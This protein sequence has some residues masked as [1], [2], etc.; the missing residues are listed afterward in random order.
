MLIVMR[1]HFI[2]KRKVRPASRRG[3]DFGIE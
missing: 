1:V 2:E 3:T